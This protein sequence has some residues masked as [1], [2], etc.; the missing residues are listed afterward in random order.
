MKRAEDLMPGDI[1]R[2]SGHYILFTRTNIAAS[3]V[4]YIWCPVGN[5][6]GDRSEVHTSTSNIQDYLDGCAVT[7]DP[8]RFLTDDERAVFSKTLVETLGIKFVM[9]LL[10]VNENDHGP[11]FTVVNLTTDPAGGTGV[12]HATTAVT[13]GDTGGSPQGQS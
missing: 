2:T 9:E 7:G 5:P 10:K 11:R 13:P 1:I 6:H 8:A 12:P 3:S 4:S